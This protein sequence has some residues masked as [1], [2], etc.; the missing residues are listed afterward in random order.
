MISLESYKVVI[1]LPGTYEKLPCEGE[2]DRFSGEQDPT[3]QT[4]THPVTLLLGLC[5]KLLVSD[6]RHRNIRFIC[7]IRQ[8]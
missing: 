4:N 5:I 7:G 8:P 3:V 2:P 1:N 6:I